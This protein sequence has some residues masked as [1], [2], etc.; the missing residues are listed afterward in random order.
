M[1]FCSLDV[2]FRFAIFICCP[3]VVVVSSD[4]QIDL[5]WRHI[6]CSCSW[7]WACTCLCV[8][9]YLSVYVSLYLS[10]RVSLYVY[11][12][13]LVLV[14]SNPSSWFYSVLLL[15][16]AFLKIPCVL[17]CQGIFKNAKSIVFLSP[18]SDDRTAPASDGRHRR[19]TAGRHRRSSLI[20]YTL[21]LFIK[22]RWYFSSCARF[23]VFP[24]K[25]LESRCRRFFLFL[26]RINSTFS[27]SLS[28]R[29]FPWK[30]AVWS[31][32]SFEGLKIIWLAQDHRF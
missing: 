2:L 16:L 11:L 26:A 1:L 21:G 23:V 29:S 4:L 14:C 6:V 3:C 15:S 31:P 22:M 10:V 12:R 8:S 30:G 13:G 24:P 25:C 32:N 28:W 18:A 9:L 19:L 17:P 27:A 5:T 20:L 7:S